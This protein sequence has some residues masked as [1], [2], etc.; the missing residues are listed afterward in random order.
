MPLTAAADAECSA[1]VDMLVPECKKIDWNQ[2]LDYLSSLEDRGCVGGTVDAYQRSLKKFFEFLPEEKEISADTVSRWRDSLMEEGYTARTINAF[3]S[4]VNGFLDYVDLRAYQQFHY[5]RL[6]QGEDQPELTR[7]EYLRLLST[8]RQLGKERIYLLIKS[9]AVIGLTVRDLPN[10]TAEAVKENCLVL[11]EETQAR[12]VHIPPPLQKELLAYIRREGISSGPVFVTLKGR[13]L[14]R[15]AVTE[16]IQ[17]LAQ[18]AQVA[19]E[20]CNPRCLRKLYCKTQKN[21]QSSFL[22]LM[23]QA[24]ERLLETEQISI[25]WEGPGPD[26]R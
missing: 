22:Q 26:G 3:L 18:D 1:P 14:C 23:E 4:T 16:S 24:Y 17:K 13:C 20:K 7:N 25:G 2:A 12:R 5:L 10:L 19:P 8:A 21:I 15:T 6:H 11:S 9:F